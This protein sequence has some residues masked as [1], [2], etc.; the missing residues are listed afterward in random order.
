MKPW[1]KQQ[2][3]IPAVSGEFVWR[4]EDVLDLYAAPYDARRPTVCFDERPCQLSRDTRAP[5]PPKPGQ[6]QRYDYE[7]KREG[8]C[9]LFMTFQP[10][11]GWRKVQVT[12]RRT[13]QDFAHCM[14]ALVDEDFPDAEMI[15][16]VLDNLNTHSPASLYEAFAP[17]EARRIAHK[18][19]FH[20]TPKHGSW[21]NMA[22]VELAVLSDQCLDRRI[23]DR[24]T[25]QR[26]VK[27]WEQTRNAQKAT[28][29]WRFT[30]T[31]ARA[32][33][34]RLYPS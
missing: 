34:T 7:Y 12:A 10:L 31:E 32:K 26:E 25:M 27:A 22:E 9:N 16:V 20:H 4:M 30:T 3:C 18:L 6:P 2:W 13:K 15:R 8:T 24:D 1:L 29:Q 19:E 5:L 14:K 17:E 11:A 28:V 23:P 33:L 21:L